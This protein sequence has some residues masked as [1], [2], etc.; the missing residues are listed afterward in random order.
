MKSHHSLVFFF[1]TETRNACRRHVRS[2]GRIRF[3]RADENRKPSPGVVSARV[4]QVVE[5]LART[6]ACGR[7]KEK[8][9]PAEGLPRS[10]W[11]PRED[12]KG[13]RRA[14]REPSRE[15]RATEI[16]RVSSPFGNTL[17][18]C[19]SI[20]RNHP[21][22]GLTWSY[23]DETSAVPAEGSRGSPETSILTLGI[24]RDPAHPWAKFCPF[25]WPGT[26]SRRYIDDF[27]L[28]AREGER[29]GEGQ[30]RAGSRDAGS[31]EG[32]GKK[33]AEESALAQFPIVA[34]W[35]ANTN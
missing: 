29:E 33:D 12:S 11:S 30:R 2:V 28:R 23:C 14:P 7:R 15:S 21:R 18:D 31:R 6:Y 10:S 27:F 19:E 13:E 3:R 9:R 17:R 35:S 16:R 20:V 1:L 5:I 22:S 4:K 32:C 34:A 24:R 26:K 25:R 8:G